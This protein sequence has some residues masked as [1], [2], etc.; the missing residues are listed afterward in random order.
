MITICMGDRSMPLAWLAQAGA[1][2]I[3]FGKQKILLDFVLTWIP[4]DAK[5]MLLSD[6]FY[7]SIGLLFAWLKDQAWYDRLRLKGNLLVDPGVDDETE[8]G[9]LA[10]NVNERYLPNERL[11]GQGAGGSIGLRLKL[12]DRAD[13]FR[14]SVRSAPAI[15]Y[16]NTDCYFIRKV[17]LLFR[18]AW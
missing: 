16:C 9:E 11:S 8:T 13:L 10:R 3:G 7:P 15:D 18:R 5:V 4:D 17:K 6:P 14:S 1:A 12:G 2:N